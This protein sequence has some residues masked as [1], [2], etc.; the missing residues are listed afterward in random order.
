[1]IPVNMHL[2]DR[3]M[4]KLAQE[5]KVYKLQQKIKNFIVNLFFEGTIY[6]ANS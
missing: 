2:T 3:I 1:M 5:Q 4:H 6:M